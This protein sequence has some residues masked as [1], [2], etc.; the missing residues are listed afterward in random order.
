MTETLLTRDKM[1]L[2]STRARTIPS[3]SYVRPRTKK[4]TCDQINIQ[5]HLLLSSF[6]SPIKNNCSVAQIPRHSAF[7]CAYTDWFVPCFSSL[8]LFCRAI[9]KNENIRLTDF[10][11]Q[12]VLHKPVYHRINVDLVFSLKEN[13][14][15]YPRLEY[16]VC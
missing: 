6:Y 8:V 4:S 1:I 14:I 9:S 2:L 10:G 7:P 3:A 13:C 16:V 11:S 15:H 5:F 12:A